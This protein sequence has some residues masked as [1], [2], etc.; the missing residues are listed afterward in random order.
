MPG[1]ADRAKRYIPFADGPR[2]CIGQSLAQTTLPI[3]LGAL[4][5]HFSFRL[6]DQVSRAPGSLSD[7]KPWSARELNPTLTSWC[8]LGTVG[9]TA[10]F[11]QQPLCC[12]TWRTP[13]VK[14]HAQSAMQVKRPQ[15]SGSFLF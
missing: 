13:S 7:A 12:V 3:T 14:V 5:S 1:G 8:V 15:C 11:V 4:L 2:N 9:D 10:G 6:A